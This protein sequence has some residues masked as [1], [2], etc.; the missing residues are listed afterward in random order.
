MCCHLFAVAADDEEGSGLGSETSELEL[1][2][3]AE[4]EL[5][6]L[7]SGEMEYIA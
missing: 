5:P 1:E 6:S 7:S 4:I 2:L 3:L